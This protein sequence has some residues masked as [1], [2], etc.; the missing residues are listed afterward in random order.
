LPFTRVS[1]PSPAAAAGATGKNTRRATT[2]P[3]FNA[4]KLL[5][6]RLMRGEHAERVDTSHR[7]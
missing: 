3:P 2:S 4:V 5:A 1:E 7:W 6:T